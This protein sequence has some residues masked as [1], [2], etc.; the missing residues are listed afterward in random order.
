MCPGVHFAP[1]AHAA[2]SQRLPR[3]RTP[4]LRGAEGSA[5]RQSPSPGLPGWDGPGPRSPHRPPRAAHRGDVF[6]PGA[7][8][9]RDAAL[10]RVE[11]RG[12][13]SWHLRRQ[14]PLRPRDGPEVPVTP[15]DAGGPRLS[16]PPGAVVVPCDHRQPGPSSGCS[17]P[18]QGTSCSHVRPYNTRHRVF[19]CHA[20]C[21]THA[22][23]VPLLRPLPG[24]PG[25]SVLLCDLR[26]RRVCMRVWGVGDGAQAPPDVEAPPARLHAGDQ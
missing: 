4:A 15:A 2:S 21:H 24:G 22:S 6:K 18:P 12:Q 5:L 16:Q 7:P 26:S 3:G 14:R 20:W 9:R 23:L 10:Q 8:G 1:S 25:A 19:T 11:G 13:V 17:L